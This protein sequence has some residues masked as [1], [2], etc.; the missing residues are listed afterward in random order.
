MRRTLSLPLSALAALA[1]LV[2][3]G[4]HSSAPQETMHETAQAVTASLTWTRYAAEATE[5]G[6]SAKIEYWLRGSEVVR[7]Y[8]QEGALLYDERCAGRQLTV[9]EMLPSGEEDKPAF[10]YKEVSDR[11][12]DESC[13][14]A[15]THD[16]LQYL[17]NPGSLAQGESVTTADGRAALRWVGGTG[18][19]FVVDAQTSLPVRVDYGTEDG[20][21][22]IA[23]GT[24]SV[25]TE[26]A[27]PNAPEVEWTGFQE[28]L[29]V[30]A[31]EVGMKQGLATV[32][33]T[34]EGLS[35]SHSRSFRTQNLAV[36]TYY[37]IWG[38]DSRNIQMVTTVATLPDELLGYSADG[39]EYNAQDGDRHVK[40]G[41]IGGDANLL[42]ASLKV[43][44]P[45][46]LD[47]P[48]VQRDPK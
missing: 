42:R 15:A 22:T 19:E 38:D 16:E 28:M 18:Q 30:P 25:T 41:T 24:F 29:D 31:G 27:R 45:A 46:A 20:I 48:R 3:C 34:V 4:I 7:Q 1:A 6:H 47:D 13:F 5:D 35:L 37:L 23:F 26:A 11:D 14:A 39:T 2:A 12:D 32:P 21:A 8:W 17:H 43:L 44:R 9:R 36:P 10:T 33:A 40:I